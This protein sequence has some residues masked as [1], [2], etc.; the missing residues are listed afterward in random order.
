MLTANRVIRLRIP[1]WEDGLENPQKS[2]Y[3]YA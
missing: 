1:E 2:E 3:D